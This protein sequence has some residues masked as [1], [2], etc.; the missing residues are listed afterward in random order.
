M[1]KSY[2]NLVDKSSDIKGC[3]RDGLSESTPQE[4]LLT[5]KLSVF[6]R[7]VRFNEQEFLAGKPVL[8]IKYF[9]LGSQNTNLFHPFND[10]L[11]YILAIYFVESE[12][13]KDNIDRFLSDSLMAPLTKKLSY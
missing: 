13:T 9:H 3:T 2:R 11:D 12:T 5:S 1:E 4:G 7:E 6:L 10:Q 8:D